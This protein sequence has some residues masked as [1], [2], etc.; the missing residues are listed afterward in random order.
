M[1]MAGIEHGDAAGKID[2]A[3]ALDIPDL[4]VFGALCVNLKSVA[5]TPRHRIRPP[6]SPFSIAGH[7]GFL[8]V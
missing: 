7:A 4:S 3:L 1:A 5:N 2:I 6:F 8:I